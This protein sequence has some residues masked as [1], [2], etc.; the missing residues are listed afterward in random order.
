MINKVN[1]EQRLMYIREI[2]L[3]KAIQ[4]RVNGE[5]SF[6]RNWTEYKVGFGSPH[7]DYWIGKEKILHLIWLNKFLSL[8][9]QT[10]K[11]I[12]TH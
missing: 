3:L 11:V 5:E 8:Q 10:T 9:M 2:F 12:L 4:R 1:T 6:N 7:E